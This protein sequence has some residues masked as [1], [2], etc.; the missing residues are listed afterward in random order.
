MIECPECGAD[1]TCPECEQRG[2]Q[3]EMARDYIT[4][5]EEKAKAFDQMKE[6]L[7]VPISQGPTPTIRKL[8]AV[9]ETVL[10]H[11]SRSQEEQE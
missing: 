10:T 6:T 9:I 1:I 5:Q 8:R 3:D 4:L 11:D 7:K 2:Y